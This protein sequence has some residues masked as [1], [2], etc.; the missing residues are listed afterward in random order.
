[1]N[2][3]DIATAVDIAPVAPKYGGECVADI[4]PALLGCNS[5]ASTASLSLLPQEIL[6]AHAIVMVVLDGL[7]WEQMMQ[8]A[9]SCP[10]LMDMSAQMITTV[11]PSTTAAALTSITTGVPPGEHGIVGYRIPTSEGNLNVLGWR[12]PRGDARRRI[13]PEDFQNMQVFGGHR[14]PV[15]SAAK[16]AKSG[17]TRAHLSGTRYVGV[18][19]TSSIVVEIRQLLAGGEA[20]IYAYYDGPDYIAHMHGF[21]EHYQAELLFCDRMI[22]ELLTVV[23]KGTSVIVTSDHGLI[24]CSSGVTMIAGEV[25]EH[26]KAESG[27]HRFRWLH[28]KAGRARYLYE[29]ANSLHG[30]QAWVLTADEVIERGWLGTYVTDTARSRLG[31]VALVAQGH[32]AFQCPSSAGLLGRTAVQGVSESQSVSESSQKHLK[33]RHGSLTSAEMLVPMLTYVK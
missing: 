14:P 21:G 23:P 4:V 28:A 19:K 2:A 10:T 33:G 27:E 9:Q 16:Y 31:S 32:Y 17:L 25:W 7:G 12:T 1:M 15:V 13:K 6:E 18:H 20:F 8:H 30:D 29:A 26:C 11:A 5:M 22:A 24:D 3:A